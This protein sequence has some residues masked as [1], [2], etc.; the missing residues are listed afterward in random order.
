MPPKGTATPAKADS[1]WSKAKKLLTHAHKELREAKTISKTLNA[2]GYKNASAL[3]AMAGYGR[4]RPV[5]RR[6]PVRRRRR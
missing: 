6:A 3:A 2:A 4:R 5:R 1:L